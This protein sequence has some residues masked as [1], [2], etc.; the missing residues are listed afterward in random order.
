RTKLIL[1]SAGEGIYGLDREGKITFL[2]PAAAQMLRVDENDAVGKMM[3]EIV[4]HASADGTSFPDGAHPLLAPLD[5]GVARRGTDEMFWRKDGKRIPTEYTSTPIMERGQVT[6][7]VVT[8]SDVTERKL[9]ERALAEKADLARAHAELEQFAYVASH[10]LKEPL[11]MVASY[12]QLLAKRY[13]GKLDAD[14]DEFIGYTV[15]GALRMQ[16]LIEGLL[17]YSRIGMEAQPFEPTDCAAVLRDTLQ[18]LSV[19]IQESGAV[20]T[21]DPLPTVMA[22]KSQIVQL[23]QNLIGNAIKF[24]GEQR[25]EIHIASERTGEEWLF[26]VRDNGIGV[27]PQYHERIFVIFQR[28]HARKDYPGTGIGLAICKRIVERHRGRIWAESGPGK[29]AAFYFTLP[30]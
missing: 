30:A 19:S 22:D 23:F 12:T 2:N 14:A 24:R 28:L 7:A 21:H 8:F 18:S 5:D 1:D 3:H 25:S 27:A 15:D 11:R 16:G 20:I 26:S 9:A 4:H 13:R 6:G 17:A 10:D 29:G